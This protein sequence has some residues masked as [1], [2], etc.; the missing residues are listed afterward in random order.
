MI[1]YDVY[2]RPCSVLYRVSLCSTLHGRAEFYN[3][4]LQRWM[5]S[6]CTVGLVI[7][8][9]HSTLVARNVVFKVGSLC[10]Q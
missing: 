1:K 4:Y 10:S 8:S 5:P 7:T 9:K 6:Y 3:R 2:K